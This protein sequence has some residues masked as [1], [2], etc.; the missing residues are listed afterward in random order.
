MDLLFR[1]EVYLGGF[2]Y[3]TMS[4]D[5]WDAHKCPHETDIDLAEL[6]HA[7]SLEF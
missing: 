5:W 2:L 1:V 3:G 4:C 7:T 6:Q